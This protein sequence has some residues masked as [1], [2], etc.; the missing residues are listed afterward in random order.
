MIQTVDEKAER[1]AIILIEDGKTKLIATI[2]KLT[3]KERE[4]YVITCNCK[5][6][7]DEDEEAVINWNNNY[8]DENKIYNEC[9]TIQDLLTFIEET[10][11][12]TI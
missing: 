4:T 1:Q 12:K 5:I 2:V 6:S 8:G 10:K 7:K 9:E 11:A 3:T